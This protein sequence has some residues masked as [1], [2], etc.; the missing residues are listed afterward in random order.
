MTTEQKNPEVDFSSIEVMARLAD[1]EIVAREICDEWLLIT[2]DIPKSEAGDKARAEFLHEARRCGA[3]MYTESVYLMPW[4]KHAEAL[5]L[6]LAQAGQVCVWTA[7]PTDSSKAPEITQDYDARL[8]PVLTEI[9]GRIDKIEGHQNDNHFGRASK[10]M[11]KTEQMLTNIEATI[12]RR[13]SA[14]L[15][16][17]LTLIKRRFEG[18]VI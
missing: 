11:I 16:I 15:Y 6:Q 13:G 10:M 5:A 9:A 8:R 7:H 17:L 3:M 12:V 4:T 18:V 14:Q 1:V 2:Y